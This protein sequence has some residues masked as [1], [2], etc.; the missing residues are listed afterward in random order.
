MKEIIIDKYNLKNPFK[1]SA[2]FDFLKNAEE[3]TWLEKNLFAHHN[4]F[5]CNVFIILEVQENTRIK[6]K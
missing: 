6:E 4:K 5:L 3:I 2:F 1:K